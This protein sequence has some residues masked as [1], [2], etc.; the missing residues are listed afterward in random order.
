MFW[1]IGHVFHLLATFSFLPPHFPLVFSVTLDSNI[2]NSDAFIV[3]LKATAGK[4][5]FFNQIVCYMKVEIL[6][7]LPGSRF[8]LLS[9]FPCVLRVLVCLVK[10]WVPMTE[11]SLWSLGGNNNNISIVFFPMYK[12]VSHMERTAC[13]VFIFCGIS[14]ESF[15]SKQFTGKSLWELNRGITH[16]LGFCNCKCFLIVSVVCT[17]ECTDDCWE[18][19][20]F[21]YLAIVVMGRIWHIFGLL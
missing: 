20:V 4:F 2:T 7:Y 8:L 12:L 3:F 9:S 18:N 14:D 19:V 10:Q 1:D 11:C 5:E 6:S 15:A 16:I 17:H 13:F 21:S